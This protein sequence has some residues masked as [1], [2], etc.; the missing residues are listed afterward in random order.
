M[1]ARSPP[2]SGDSVS[3]VEVMGCPKLGSKASLVFHHYS[4]VMLGGVCQRWGS[5]VVS[6]SQ[7]H[8]LMDVP[9]LVILGGVAMVELPRLH[10]SV[11]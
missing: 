8:L 1:S 5:L 4:L 10:L 6:V 7:F 11:E 9:Y 3:L 2:T